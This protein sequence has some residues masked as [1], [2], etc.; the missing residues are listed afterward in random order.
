MSQATDRVPGTGDDNG[1]WSRDSMLDLAWSTWLILLAAPFVVLPFALHMTPSAFGDGPRPALADRWFR[2]VMVYLLVA[3][4]AALLIR[5]YVFRGLRRGRPVLP[6]AY[7][8]GML[9][10]WVVVAAA[11]LASELACVATATLVPNVLPALLALFVYL[12]LWP[13]GAA[14]EP[15]AA[16]P[17]QD[18][19]EEPARPAITT[20]RAGEEVR[21]A[22]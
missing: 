16:E 2:I 20:N 11:G 1:A 17:R 12:M 10:V 4:P 6:R 19:G 22:R 18:T 21:H 7:Y 5:F 15:R 8:I 9:I 14:M 13:T 3:L